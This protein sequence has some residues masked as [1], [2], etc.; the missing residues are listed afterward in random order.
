[1][2]EIIIIAAIAKNNVIGR[3]SEI[4]WHISEDFKHFKELTMNH[5]VIMGDKTYESLTVKPL[6]GRENIVLT[7]DK[8]YHPAGAIIKYSFQEALDHCRDKKKVFI[9]GGASVYKHGLEVADILELTRIHRDFDG[10]VF[11]PEINF[12]EWELVKKVDKK[13]NTYGPYSFLT[14]KR[15]K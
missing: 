3:G 15:K 10:D 6:P 5:P 7:F 12:D 1:M 2:S 9:I 4:P 14:Y 13:D 11:F 8:N